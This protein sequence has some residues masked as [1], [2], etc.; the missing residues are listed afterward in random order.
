MNDESNPKKIV[1]INEKK[2]SIKKEANNK[3]NVEI[4]LQN[5]SR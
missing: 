2:L 1:P 5:W 3:S 4:I